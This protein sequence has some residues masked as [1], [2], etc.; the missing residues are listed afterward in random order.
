MEQKLRCGFYAPSCETCANISQSVTV[1]ACGTFA[2]VGSAHGSISMFNL[3]SGIER[4]RFPTT[5]TPGQAKRLKATYVVGGVE[6]GPKKFAMGEGKHK[7]AVTGLMVDTLNRKVI[8]CGLDG[9]V[10]FWDFL[11]GLLQEEID[12]FPMTTITASQYCRPSDLIALSCDDLSIRV[13]DI[14]TKKLVRELWGCLGQISDFC[15]SNDGRWIIAASMDSVV[16]VWDLPTGHLINA[17]RMESPCTALA[18]SDTG[19]YLATAHSDGVGINIW[20]NRTLFAHVPT[21]S[22]REDEIIDAVPPTASGESGRNL[23]EAVFDKSND[24]EEEAKDP[25]HGDSTYNNIDPTVSQLSTSLQTLSLVP[26]SR[27]QTLLHLDTIAQRNKPTE[28][29]KAPEKAPFFLPSLSDPLNPST[30][31]IQPSAAVASTAPPPQ[32]NSRILKLPN[33]NICS[34]DEFTTLLQ[35]SFNNHE[36]FIAHLS[37]LP[38]SAADVQIRSLSPHELILFVFALTGRLRQ[39]RDYELIQ[40]WMAVFLKVHG[41][42]VVADQRLRDVLGDWRAVQREEAG[43][44]AAKM[45]FCGGV[46]AWVRSE[47]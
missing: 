28:P 18:F 8:S 30:A 44:L 1:T 36:P 29:P 33:P 21:R 43:R 11:T 15:F 31:S 5:L 6:N 25:V 40:T 3:Q 39:K 12:W 10:K 9:K 41:E 16:R 38:P 26:R 20:N 45:G 22:I 42:S 23:I 19:E 7:K 2:L 34:K 17:L 24:D 27:W 35:S 13:V 4:Q 47:R 37:S 14:D 46:L 32:P